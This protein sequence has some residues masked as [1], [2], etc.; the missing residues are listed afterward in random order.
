MTPRAVNSG[1]AAAAVRPSLLLGP[2][3]PALLGALC[4]L[5]TLGNGF[6]YD[7]NS[8]VRLNPLIHSLGDWRSIWLRDWWYSQGEQGGGLTDPSRDRLYRPLTTFSFALNYAVHGLHPAGFHAVNVALHAG[9]CALVWLLGRRLFD[10]LNVASIA[11]V[12]FAVH[13]IHAE[14]VAG[15]VGR[16]EILATLFMLLGL[17]AL[18]PRSGPVAAGRAV[19]SA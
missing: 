10:D 7:D 5:N 11:A 18:L 14:P 17:V 16:A 9:V 12:I 15:L 13:P 4:Y 6:A 3:L 1:S 2:W 8:I 19:L